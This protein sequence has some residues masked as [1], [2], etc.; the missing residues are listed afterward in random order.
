MAIEEWPI[1]KLKW[2]TETPV[3]ID[4]WQLSKEKLAH[5]NELVD[6]H[7]KKRHIPSTSPWNM[8]IFT[9]PKKNQANG[10]YYMTFEPSIL[11]FRIWDPCNLAYLRLQCYLSIDNW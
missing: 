7:L 2:L 1:L 5:F 4:Q 6:E 3:W 9:I 10:D 8:P 11:R